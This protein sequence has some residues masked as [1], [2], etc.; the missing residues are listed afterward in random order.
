MNKRAELEQT[1]LAEVSLSKSLYQ[2]IRHYLRQAEN[3]N[4]SPYERSSLASLVKLNDRAWANILDSRERIRELDPDDIDRGEAIS[5]GRAW[6][7][8][9]CKRCNTETEHSV[10]SCT[11]RHCRIEVNRRYRK[12]HKFQLLRYNK[13]KGAEDKKIR[14]LIND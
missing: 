2:R 6:Y 5:Q 1:I 9:T 14:E 12:K 4:L 11:C 3:R 7:F 10:S 13:S 8:G